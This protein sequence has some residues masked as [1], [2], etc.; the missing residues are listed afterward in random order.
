MKYTRGGTF[1]SKEKKR[2]YTHIKAVEQEVLLMLESGKTQRE[3]AEHF[4]FKDK[5]VVKFFVLRHRRNQRLCEAGIVPR[6]RGR[7]PKGYVPGESEKDNEIKLLRMENQL[8]RSFLQL[9]GRR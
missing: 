5:Y 1:M 7:P 6:K 2:E 3:V 9:A 4:G 8:L